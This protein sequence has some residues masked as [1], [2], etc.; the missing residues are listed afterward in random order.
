MAKAMPDAVSEEAVE[1]VAL[2]FLDG[3]SSVDRYGMQGGSACSTSNAAAKAFP[4]AV[5]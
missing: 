5:C 1:H 3:G 2:Q 4:Q